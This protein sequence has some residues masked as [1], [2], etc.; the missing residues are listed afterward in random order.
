MSQLDQRQIEHLSGLMDER[1]DR[2]LREIRSLLAGL[3]EER[4]RTTLGERPADTSDEALLD[5][6]ATI[7][8]ALVRQNVQDMRDIAAARRRLAAGTYGVCTD[9][10]RDIGYERLLAYPTAKRC[11]DCQREHER[12][13]APP[14]MHSG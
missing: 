6:L 4:E 5:T 9:C 1:W 14:G 8:Q 13:I 11:I 3:D 7:E 12:R 10:G 2:E